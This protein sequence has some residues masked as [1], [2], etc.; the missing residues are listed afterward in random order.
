MIM[1]ANDANDRKQ[2]PMNASEC[3]E[4]QFKSMNVNTAKTIVDINNTSHDS[5][6]KEIELS[7]KTLFSVLDHM[8]IMKV[9]FR[10]FCLLY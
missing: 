3:Q 9:M 6:R 8:I 10:L 4:C 1:N 7:F 5:E 2:M